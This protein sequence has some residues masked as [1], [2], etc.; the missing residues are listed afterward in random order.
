MKTL[1][2]MHAG[3]NPGL[4]HGDVHWCGH[5]HWTVV[6][7]EHAKKDG[8]KKGTKIDG[9]DWPR[10]ELS[11]AREYEEPKFTINGHMHVRAQKSVTHEAVCTTTGIA[12]RD[13]TRHLSL[14]YAFTENKNHMHDRVYSAGVQI[15]KLGHD[16][17]CHNGHGNVNEPAGELTGAAEFETRP[18][19][20][21]ATTL[22]FGC[23]HFAR[24]SYNPEK[25][26]ATREVVPRT[27]IPQPNLNSHFKLSL[28][29][30]RVTS[31]SPLCAYHEIRTG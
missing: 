22:N 3:L 29:P 17:G 14:P 19:F 15:A 21:Y 6:V 7:Y 8:G 16:H 30:G 12:S 20:L 9:A 27:C 28:S 13:T 11:H 25:V 1:I 31:N 4:G 5:W 24:C 18:G 2:R 10:E 23:Q 26:N